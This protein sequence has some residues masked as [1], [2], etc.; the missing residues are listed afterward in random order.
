MSLLNLISKVDDLK[1]VIDK[2][3]DEIAK[4]FAKELLSNTMEFNDIQ[5]MFMK[6]PDEIA[7]EVMMKTMSIVSKSTSVSEPQRNSRSFGS[8]KKNWFE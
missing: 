4:D 2:K 8:T 7:M 5:K 3:T 6:I 1:S